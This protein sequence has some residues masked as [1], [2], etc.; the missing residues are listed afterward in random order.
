LTFQGKNI[1]D[2]F[3]K[4]AEEQ[5]SPY[6]NLVNKQVAAKTPEIPEKW[7]TAAGWT[8]YEAGHEPK[9]VPFPDEESMV[10]DIEECMQSGLGPTLAVAL[11]PTAWYAWISQ[12]LADVL[13]GAP[14]PG[15]KSKLTPE[16]LINLETPLQCKTPLENSKPK[17]NIKTSYC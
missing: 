3:K 10:F 16:D 11:S 4:I 5:S 14:E 7:S 15:P 12:P 17:V 9:Q 6:R 2:H 1:E 8:K 13:S